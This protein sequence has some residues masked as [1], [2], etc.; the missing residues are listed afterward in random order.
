M[1]GLKWASAERLRRRID[2]RRRRWR[3]VAYGIAIAVLGPTATLQWLMID[4]A[5]I[6]R[7]RWIE[8]RDNLFGKTVAASD[9]RAAM[10]YG[11]AIH[12]FKNYILRGELIFAE[13]FAADIEEVRAGLTA[14]RAAEMNADRRAD[15]AAI[16]KTIDRYANAVTTA[17]TL[18]ADG[19]PPSVIDGKV[20]IDDREAEAALDR[21]DASLNAELL[22]VSA[23]ISSSVDDALFFS[24]IGLATTLGVFA[25][26]ALVILMGEYLIG[27]LR[28]RVRAGARKS[29]QLRTHAGAL[30]RA[31]DAL[32]G[33]RQP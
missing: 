1:A 16:S 22:S 21:L 17:Q 3:A 25:F 6:Q 7:E 12:T 8:I 18:W 33:Q 20:R 28:R 13:R 27:L 24:R 5:S 9:V 29:A 15:L 4:A 31:E 10:G 26:G 30:A 14:W 19:G 32:P 11:G 23:R 2:L